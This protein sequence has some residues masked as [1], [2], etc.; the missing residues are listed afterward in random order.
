MILQFDLLHP[1]IR[2]SSEYMNCFSCF[3]LIALYSV[4]LTYLHCLAFAVE[5]NWR[6]RCWV[7]QRDQGM[8]LWYGGW[9]VSTFEQMDLTHLGAMCME[10]FSSLQRIPSTGSKW[11]SYIILWLWKGT[12][13]DAVSC[14]Y[15]MVPDNFFFATTNCPVD[16]SRTKMLKDKYLLYFACDCE[17]LAHAIFPS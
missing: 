12:P 10:V 3:M 1:S 4:H 16:L 13:R 5:V 15:L 2:F 7:V 14:C 6:G 17:F 9:R 11:S 8:C